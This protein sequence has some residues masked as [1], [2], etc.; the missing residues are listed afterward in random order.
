[1]RVVKNASCAFA[2]NVGIA[3]HAYQGTEMEYDVQAY[4]P[5]MKRNYTMHCVFGGGT[6]ITCSGGNDA[7]IDVWMNIGF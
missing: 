2:N 3:A 5:A 6:D 4:S 7:V 1:M